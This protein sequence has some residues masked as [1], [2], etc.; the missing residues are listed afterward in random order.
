MLQVTLAEK[1]LHQH[2]V[3]CQNISTDQQALLVCQ[4]LWLDMSNVGAGGGG[5]S[6]PVSSLELRSAL[7][8][9]GQLLLKSS[10]G[11]MTMILLRLVLF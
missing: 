10:F 9:S 8:V 4:N 2:G 6:D 11:P 5:V 3:M 7:G 1:Y